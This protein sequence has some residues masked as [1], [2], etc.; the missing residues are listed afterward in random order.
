MTTRHDAGLGAL[1]RAAHSGG[2]RQTAHGFVLETLREAILSGD[3][4]AGTH[5]VQSDLA[6]TLNVSTTPVREALRDLAADGLVQLDAHRGGIVAE[7]DNR[8]LQEIYDLRVMLE[9]EVLRRAWPRITDEIVE[10]VAGLQRR[11]ND[12]KTSASWVA[13]NSEF[14]WTVY[15]QAAS[16]RLLAMLKGLTDPW[17]MYVSAAMSRDPANRKRASEGHDQILDALRSRDLDAAIRATLDHL[18]ITRAA[19][20]LD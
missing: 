1:A 15:S 20:H 14:H 17:V 6:E 18:S 19:L 16:P 11:M 5:L 8:Q 9:P 10:K 7:L 2:R 3:L 4:P 12:A 13:L